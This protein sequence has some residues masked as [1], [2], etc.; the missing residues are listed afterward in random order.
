MSISCL[1]IML[2]RRSLSACPNFFVLEV[3]LGGIWCKWGERS[4][5][6]VM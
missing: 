6:Y 1:F 2:V 5:A 4:C 3:A